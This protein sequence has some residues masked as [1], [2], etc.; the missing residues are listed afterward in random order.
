[1]CV[2]SH[3]I[4]LKEFVGALVPVHVCKTWGKGMAETDT[5]PHPM[6]GLMS[7]GLTKRSVYVSSKC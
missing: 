6:G 3:D 7:N 5:R 2:S 4:S 1:M